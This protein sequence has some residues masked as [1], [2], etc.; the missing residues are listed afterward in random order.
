MHSTRIVLPVVAALVLAGCGVGFGPQLTTPANVAATTDQIDQVTVSW[1]AVPGADRYY[2]YRS[3]S[4]DES[5]LA[6]GPYGPVPYAATNA[7]SFVDVTL[8]GNYYY[9]LSAVVDLTGE[10]SQPSEVVGGIS[11]DGPPAWDPAIVLALDSLASLRLAADRASLTDFYVLTVPSDSDAV[12]VTVRRVE[13]DGTLEQVGSAFA[14]ARGG[15]PRSA[16]VAAHDGRVLVALVNASAEVEIWSYVEILGVGDFVLANTIDAYDASPTPLLSLAARSADEF[17]LAYRDAGGELRT[18]RLDRAGSETEVAPP[19]S[20]GNTT[21]AIVADVELAASDVAVAIAW[22]VEDDGGTTT[23][24]AAA[25]TAGGPAATWTAAAGLAGWPDPPDTGSTGSA[26]VSSLDVAVSPGGE[27]SVVLADASGLFL[28]SGAA[29]DGGA[30]SGAGDPTPSPPAVA[31]A[32][33]ADDLLLFHADA[34]ADAG[35]VR[36]SDDGASWSTV[37]TED[38]TVGSDDLGILRIEALGGRLVAAYE[39]GDVAAFVRVYR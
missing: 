16:D 13:P 19:Y 25:T 18:F 33:R 29:F 17:W 27:P 39:T 8:A 1:E 36:S 11:V 24:A 26:T 28:H 6:E 2:V 12:E 30:L 31:L 20:G 35:V 7:T 23:S 37:S 14:S 5:P 9:Q 15:V 34:G 4:A 38:F 21:D 10:E 3:T 22:E 32:A